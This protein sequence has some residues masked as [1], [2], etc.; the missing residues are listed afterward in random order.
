VSIIG[1]LWASPT[2]L[3][4]DMGD[5]AVYEPELRLREFGSNANGHT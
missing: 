4:E 2:L 1:N 5:I 3:M